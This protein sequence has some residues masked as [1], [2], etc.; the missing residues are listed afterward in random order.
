MTS[1]LDSVPQLTVEVQLIHYLFP[2]IELEI[3]EK[4]VE[5]RLKVNC[6]LWNS[7]LSLDNGLL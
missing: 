3:N 5:P 6:E 4:Q 7:A 1:D 2:I